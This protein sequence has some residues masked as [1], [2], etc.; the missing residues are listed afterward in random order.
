MKF[1]HIYAI[2]RKPGDK[3]DTAFDWNKFEAED[4]DQAR[5]KFIAANPEVV[6]SSI[7]IEEQK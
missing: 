2:G 5:E 7:A 4:R 3:G 1:F 6:F